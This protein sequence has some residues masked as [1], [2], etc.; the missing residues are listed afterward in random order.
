MPSLSSVAQ[1]Y[2]KTIMLKY[3]P[4]CPDVCREGIRIDFWK[5]IARG[6]DI[7]TGE[8]G[9]IDEDGWHHPITG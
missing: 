7:F 6:P 3:G 2:C 1:E 9:E 4:K 5:I 8:P